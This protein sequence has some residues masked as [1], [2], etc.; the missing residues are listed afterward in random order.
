MNFSFIK[1]AQKE[2]PAVDFLLNKINNNTNKD[3]I[4]YL[5]KPIRLYIFTAGNCL[6]E[7]ESQFECSEFSELRPLGVFFLR[8]TVFG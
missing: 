4:C 2:C 8:E 7:V 6:S 5:L 3:H 1:F